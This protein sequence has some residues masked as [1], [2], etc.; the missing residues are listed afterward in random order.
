MSTGAIAALAA[1]L[2]LLVLGF[3]GGA[4]WKGRELAKVRAADQAAAIGRL[5]AV[6]ADN[7]TLRGKVA[8][9]AARAGALEAQ[10]STAL[11]AGRTRTQTRTVFREVY[12]NAN[13][14]CDA[15]LRAAVPCRLQQQPGPGAGHPGPDH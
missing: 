7:E 11:E 1:A 14:D 15:W 5:E 2:V 4:D 6:N 9:E 13:P 8:A 3:W 10:L 12:R